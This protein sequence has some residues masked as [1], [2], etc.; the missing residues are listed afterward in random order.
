VDG[1]YGW[2]RDI[3][4]SGIEAARGAEKLSLLTLNDI[5]ARLKNDI[6]GSGYCNMLYCL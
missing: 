3:F 5:A 4:A 2:S 1:D 6:R